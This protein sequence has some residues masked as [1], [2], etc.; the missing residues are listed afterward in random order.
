MR[1]MR[2]AFATPQVR[3]QTKD[4][5]RRLGWLQLKAGEPFQPV[6]KA[7]GLRRGESPERRGGPV[8]T[9]STRREPLRR[10]VDDPEYGHDE[11][12]RE[13]FPEMSPAEFVAMFCA[14]HRGCTPD[15]EVT[16]I[17]FQYGE[18]DA[19]SSRGAA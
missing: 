18:R 13:G 14:A 3:A 15:T 4:V 1:N 8:V 6:A 17:E 2:F 10:M 11:C 5:T 9:R 19:R 16:R 12:R 7:M